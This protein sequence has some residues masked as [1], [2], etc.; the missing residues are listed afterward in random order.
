M[1]VYYYFYL[2]PA[3]RFQALIMYA[4]E[5]LAIAHRMPVRNSKK[6]MPNMY[7]DRQ[8]REY[9]DAEPAGDAPDPPFMDASLSASPYMESF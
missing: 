8:F 9:G 5:L 3:S 6:W 7:S 2:T 4:S 1:I